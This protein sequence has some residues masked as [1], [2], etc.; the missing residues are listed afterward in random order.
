MHQNS[1]PE[2]FW[3]IAMS[4]YRWLKRRGW[5]R[6]TIEPI[7]ITAYEKILSQLEQHQPD[8][9]SEPLSRREQIIL[10]LEYHKYGIPRKLVRKLFYETCGEL[11]GKS[12]EDGGLG[13][14]RLI[15]AYSRPKNLRDLLQRARLYEQS[16]REVS[17]YL[18]AGTST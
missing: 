1:N 9:Q 17:T 3:K 2:D 18:A 8:D 6:A 12:I 7:F 5:E 4:F 11:F 15:L 13:I 14:E 16:E 10:H